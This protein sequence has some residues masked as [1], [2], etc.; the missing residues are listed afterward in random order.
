[1]DLR[2]FLDKLD[3]EG[4]FYQEINRR[5]AKPD[6]YI[7]SIGDPRYSKHMYMTTYTISKLDPVHLSKTIMNIKLKLLFL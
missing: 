5:G 7:L 2:S 4:I 3:E 6:R 1:M